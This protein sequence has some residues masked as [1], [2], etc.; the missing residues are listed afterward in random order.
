LQLN[1][2]RLSNGERAE[3]LINLSGLTGQSIYLM[4][5]GSELPRESSV[6]TALVT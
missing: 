6:L 3:I 1:R 5:Y 2:L 4:N